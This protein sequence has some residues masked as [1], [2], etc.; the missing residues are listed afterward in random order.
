MIENFLTPGVRFPGLKGRLDGID[1]FVN[2]EWVRFP[3]LKGRLDRIEN[4]VNPGWVRF[5]WD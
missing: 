1:N 3:G 2:P 5:P 4:F